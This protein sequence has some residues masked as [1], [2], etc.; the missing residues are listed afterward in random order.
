[1]ND[2]S[3]PKKD[4]EE[5][6]KSHSHKNSTIFNHISNTFDE[7]NQCYKRDDDIDKKWCENQQL[8]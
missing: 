1:M 8:R 5:N 4:E 6:I 3:T 2:G 7:E